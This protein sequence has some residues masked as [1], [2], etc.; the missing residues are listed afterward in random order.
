MS[1]LLECINLSKQYQEGESQ[2]EVLKQVNFELQVGQQVAILGN[3]GSG[4]STLLHILGALDNPT[5]G[6]VLFKGEDI[7]KFNRK[8]QAAFRNRQLG[9]VYQLHHLLPEFSAL[10]NVAMPLL[11]GKLDKKSATTRA[12]EILDRVGL[13]HRLSHKP[14]QLSGGERQR[15]AFARALVTNPAIVLADEPTGNLDDKTGET[16]YQLI[17]ELRQDFNTSFVVVTHDRQLAAKLDTVWEL[18]SG[19]LRQQVSSRSETAVVTNV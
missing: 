6:Q 11:I 16:I 12:T 17:G 15:V 1:S 7:F 18:T 13:S 5:S 19:T 10:E 4:K 2:I 8:Q 9:F 14:S 3:S